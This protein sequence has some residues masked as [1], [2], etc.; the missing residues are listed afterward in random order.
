[1]QYYKLKIR[2]WDGYYKEYII[3]RY[4]AGAYLLWFQR[5]YGEERS[6]PLSQ[7]RWYE[8]QPIYVNKTESDKP[9]ETDTIQ[10]VNITNG[11]VE[12]KHQIVAPPTLKEKLSTIE[13][14]KNGD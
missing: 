14:T 4:Q 8:V 5:D 9:K 13:R 3:T 2:W 1:M 6:I 10:S 7:V 11:K 12:N